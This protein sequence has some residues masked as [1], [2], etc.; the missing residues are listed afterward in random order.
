MPIVQRRAYLIVHAEETGRGRKKYQNH[1]RGS[2][3]QLLDD[4]G[5]RWCWRQAAD[6]TGTTVAVQVHAVPAHL[7]VAAAIKQCP[8]VAQQALEAGIGETG[9][10]KIRKALSSGRP[11][12]LWVSPFRF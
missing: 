2:C 4:D 9:T 8:Q 12:D 10:P 3:K 1:S 5:R 7:C 6:R 11:S